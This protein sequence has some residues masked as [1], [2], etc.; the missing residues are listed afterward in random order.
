MIGA[1]GAQGAAE[2]PKRAALDN[3]SG[4]ISDGSAM[5]GYGPVLPLGLLHL[6]EAIEPGLAMKDAPP[7]E[8]RDE[9]VPANDLPG[10]KW[11]EAE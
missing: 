5:V 7:R 6:H 4:K 3:A 1:P 11:F 9:G 10:A 2:N 8:F